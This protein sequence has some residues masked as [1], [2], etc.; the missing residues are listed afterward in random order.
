[1]K[2]NKTNILDVENLNKIFHINNE[3]VPVLEDLNLNIA[4][5]EFI[6]IVGPSGCGKSTLLKLIISLEKKI[7][8]QLGLTERK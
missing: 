6:S 3:N 5:G 4:K 7:V 8:E 1:M 2:E